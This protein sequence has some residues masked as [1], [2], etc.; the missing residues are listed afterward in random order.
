MTLIDA[1]RRVLAFTEGQKL[2][3]TDIEAL[4]ICVG[5]WEGWRALATMLRS[6]QFRPVGE[7]RAGK[8]VKGSG[9]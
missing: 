9:T 3:A 2:D 1:A 6:A 8:V 5:D 7:R 4:R